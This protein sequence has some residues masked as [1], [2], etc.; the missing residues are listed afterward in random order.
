MK[1]LI[2]TTLTQYDTEQTYMV[3]DEEIL[4]EYNRRKE[5]FY[6][7]SFD[8]LPSRIFFSLLNIKIEADWSK[9]GWI[10]QQRNLGVFD[11]EVGY[12]IDKKLWLEHLRF[13]EEKIEGQEQLG[14]FVATTTHQHKKLK[15]K[16]MQVQIH[17]LLKNNSIANYWRGKFHFHSYDRNATG[18]GYSYCLW[19]VLITIWFKEQ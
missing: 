9:Y 17:N 16:R 12:K 3:T 15:S 14:N 10:S 1:C 8:L 19:F 5:N 2:C 11:D 6:I 18:Y 13:L 7:D 4:A